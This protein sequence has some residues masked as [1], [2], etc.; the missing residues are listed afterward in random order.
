MMIRRPSDS[1]APSPNAAPTFPLYLLPSLRIPFR[2]QRISDP[3]STATTSPSS[4]PGPT[5]P[6]SLSTSPGSP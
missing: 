6:P 1:P 5:S 2:R 3:P 4:P